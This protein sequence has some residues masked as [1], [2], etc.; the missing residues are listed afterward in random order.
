MTGDLYERKHFNDVDTAMWAMQGFIDGYGRLSDEM[1]FRTAIHA[2][3]HLIGWYTRR[4]PNAPLM[5]TPEQI[6]GAMALGRDFIVKGW[7]KDKNW[8]EGSVLAPL[9]KGS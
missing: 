5:G 9:F 8:F 7:E 1:A 4:A 6:V 3:V 2:G